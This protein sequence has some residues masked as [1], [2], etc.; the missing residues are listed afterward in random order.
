MGI[1]VT[2]GRCVLVPPRWLVKSSSGKLSRQQ[3]RARALEREGAD[4]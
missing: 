2:V 3:N 4:S 1:D